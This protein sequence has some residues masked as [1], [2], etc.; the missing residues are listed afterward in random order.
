MPV[1]TVRM[2]G[3]KIRSCGAKPTCS[4]SKRY[5]RSATAMRRSNVSAWPC[6][7]NAITTTAAPKRFATLARSRNA[8]SPSFSEIELTT[9]F[10]CRCFRPASSVGQD[11]ESSITGT[12]ATSGSA[13]RRR[14]KAA[15][16]AGP[17]M[18]PSSTFTSIICAP[19]STWTRATSTAPERSPEVTRRRKRREPVTLVRSPTFT[20]FDSGRM[21]NGSSPAK[22]GRGSGAGGT[23]GGR[24]RTASANTAMCSGVVPQHPPSTFTQPSLATS[25]NTRTISCGPSSYPPNAFGRPALG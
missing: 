3:S 21:T 19:A 6:S 14:R 16:V 9:P 24:P 11:D 20:R 23:R 12:R 25:R 2:L 17:S 18:S 7:S 15:M 10:P 1:P 5:A 13:A 22:R 8:A 4:T